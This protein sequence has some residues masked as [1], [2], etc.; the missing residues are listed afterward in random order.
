MATGEALLTEVVVTANVAELLPEVMFTLAGTAA[1]AGLALLKITVTPPAGAEAFKVTVPVDDPVPP[2]TEAGF[3]LREPIEIGLTTS[4]DV[5][6][7]PYVAEITAAELVDTSFV[8]TGKLAVIEPEGTVTL[9]GTVAIAVL[10]LDRLTVIPLLGAT[11]FSMTLPVA[12]EP[13]V[14]VLGVT[15]KE[16]RFVAGATDPTTANSARPIF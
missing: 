15:A 10:L 12:A 14:T 7:A 4:V 16:T 1:T 13:L 6:V 11:P 2:V 3:K 5:I 9:A 8:V